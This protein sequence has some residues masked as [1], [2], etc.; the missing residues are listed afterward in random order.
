MSGPT[1]AVAV[2]VARLMSTT[3]VTPLPASTGPPDN[4]GAGA[5][6][7]LPALKLPH[8]EYHLILPYLIL[9]GSALLL[10]V[11]A[12]VVRPVWRRGLYAG[13]TAITG[14]AAMVWTWHLWGQVVGHGPAPHPG[15]TSAI[16]GALVVDGFSLFIAITVCSAL[17]LTALL[18]SRYLPQ[19]RLDGPEFYVLAM[20]STSG[21][22]LMGS[23]NDLI[24]VFL[25]LEI[26]SLPLYVLAAFHRGRVRSGEAGM[27]YFILGSFSS[28]FFL[29]GVALVYGAVGTTSLAGIAAFLSSHVLPSNGVLLA[30]MALLLIGLGFKIA[31]VPFQWW[32]PDVYEGAPTPA[33]AFMSAVAKTAGFAALL[34]IFLGAFPTQAENW[35]PLIWVIAVLTLVVGAVLA[36]VQDNVK[37]ILA[38]SSI[39]HAGF[40]LLGLYA[41]TSTGPVTSNG[42]AG[43]S[44]YLL[45]YT[46][47]IVGSFAVVTVVSGRGDGHHRLA[48]YRGLAA[49][50]PV[51]ALAFTVL[52]LSQAGIPFTVGF[53]AKFDVISPVVSRGGAPDYV[54]AVI[55]MLAAAVSVYYYLRIVLAMY[56]AAPAADHE[57]AAGAGGT[58]TLVAARTTVRVPVGAGIVIAACTAFTIA[59]GIYPAPLVHFAERASLLF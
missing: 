34:R 11:V 7:S 15:P 6:G 18:A 39:N 47:M 2:A 53:I 3:P 35:R 57:P 30:G 5:T 23:A 16:N 45:A 14:L 20:I 51:L 29:Y 13:W 8:I 25:G 43:S 44:L 52:L 48:D 38:Y 24:V 9:T 12:S 27:K 58:D 4:S 56:Q 54:L 10:L 55:A 22:W 19:E 36:V 40:V 21:A 49:E 37:R 50:R 28:A 1:T 59:F 32:T 31:A 42:L 41:A 26:L 17:V 46:F 33:T